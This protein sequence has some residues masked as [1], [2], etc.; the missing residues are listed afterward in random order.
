MPDVVQIF[1]WQHQQECIQ[2]CSGFSEYLS[3][4]VS[5]HLPA[6]MDGILNLVEFKVS[7][8]STNLVKKLTIV[9]SSRNEEKSGILSHLIIQQQ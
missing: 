4:I 6:F 2:G 5:K 1:V 9:K 3:K 8:T 7:V